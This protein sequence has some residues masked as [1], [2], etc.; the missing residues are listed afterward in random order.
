M[1]WGYCREYSTKS[2]GRI[3]QVSGG[4][5][6][7]LSGG[8]KRTTFGAAQDWYVSALEDAWALTVARH[9]MGRAISAVMRSNGLKQYSLRASNWNPKLWYCFIPAQF[10]MS[11]RLWRIRST[12]HPMAVESH[13][14]RLHDTHHLRMQISMDDGVTE[15]D[16]THHIRDF[17]APCGEWHHS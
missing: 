2:A 5:A 7:V 13:L 9:T 12:E 17:T 1:H 6:G 14:E 15:L 16:S 8:L 11:K 10:E 4:S 3:T